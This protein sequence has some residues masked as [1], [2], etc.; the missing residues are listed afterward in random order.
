MVKIIILIQNN[1][2]AERCEKGKKKREAIPLSFF[3]KILMLLSRL[4]RP[5]PEQFSWP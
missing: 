4:D 5:Y 3:V 2:T 1:F